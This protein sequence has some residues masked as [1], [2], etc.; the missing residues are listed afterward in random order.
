MSH[1]RYSS[2]NPHSIPRIIVSRMIGLA[3][4]F[5]VVVV[6]ARIQ[7]NNIVLEPIISFLIKPAIIILV[8]TFSLLFLIGEVFLALGLPL[9]FPGPFFNAL[10]SVFL[11][12]FL[13]QLLYLVDQIGGITIFSLFRPLEPLLYFLVFLI[14]LI[15]QYTHLFFRKG[16]EWQETSPTRAENKTTDEESASHEDIPWNE[17]EAEFRMMLYDLFHSIRQVIKKRD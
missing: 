2:P 12:S 6:L 9:S 5:I 17:V 14:V 7:T 15:V 3:I 8:V 4:Y 10:G 1:R 11:V 13:F 16:N